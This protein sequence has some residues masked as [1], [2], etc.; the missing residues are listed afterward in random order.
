MDVMD[1]GKT[2]PGLALPSSS[3]ED[4]QD[5]VFLRGR[6]G[7]RR[8]DVTYGLQW[9]STVTRFTIHWTQN[10]LHHIIAGGLDGNADVDDSVFVRS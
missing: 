5:R 3:V 7:R 10:W 2:G 1:F 8:V 4:G 6:G 9:S